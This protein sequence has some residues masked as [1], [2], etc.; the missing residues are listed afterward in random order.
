MC[1]CFEVHFC[2]N[3]FYSTLKVSFGEL[4]NRYRKMVLIVILK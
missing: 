1:T 3:I 4:L 2:S